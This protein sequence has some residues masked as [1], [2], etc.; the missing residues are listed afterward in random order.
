[1]SRLSA[2]PGESEWHDPWTE[3]VLQGGTRPLRLLVSGWAA[4]VR[5]LADGRRQ[6]VR[7]LIP[8]D[9]CGASRYSSASTR[10]VTM[11]LTRA[12][13]VGQDD[14]AGAPGAGRLSALRAEAD[15]REH[16]GLVDQVVRLGRMSAYERTAH[17]LLE[18]FDRQSRAGLTQ[19]VSMP[20]PISQETLAD[21]LGLS[22][23]HTNR[24]LQQ[25]RREGLIVL[26]A[27][28]VT[29]PNKEALRNL[30]GYVAVADDD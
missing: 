1:M 24:V 14:V 26:R 7:I 2:R 5:A 21:A 22:I 6:I 29:F 10:L 15:A 28:R 9:L 23:V 16:A 20:L 4:H 25:L 27:G 12:H 30:C 17:L 19:G 18:L 8:G 13:T 11:A 3:I